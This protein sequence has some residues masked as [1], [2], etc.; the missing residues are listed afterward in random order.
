MTW[1][2]LLEAGDDEGPDLSTPRTKSQWPR[3]SSHKVLTSQQYGFYLTRLGSAAGFKDRLAYYCNR[4]HTANALIGK[5][6]KDDNRSQL[7]LQRGRSS[8]DLGTGAE[9]PARLARYPGIPQPADQLWYSSPR[10]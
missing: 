3:T 10:P 7:M 6:A 4:R 9:T 1:F 5:S 8:S 2:S